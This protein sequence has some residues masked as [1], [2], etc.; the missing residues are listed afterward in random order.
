LIL[1]ESISKKRFGCSGRASGVTAAS[2][3]EALRMTIGAGEA[4]PGRELALRLMS[5]AVLI[6]FGL[7]AVWSGGWY[8]AAGA[9][10][11]AFAMGYEWGRMT[12]S[13]LT[14]AIA[15]VAALLNG[16][17]PLYPQY[18][19]LALL[20]CA[21]AVFLFETGRSGRPAAGF[22]MV[23]IA[24]MPMAFQ[25]LRA[26]DG[27][28]GWALAMGTMLVVWAS[29]SAAYF[30]GRA[31]GGPQI[32]PKYSPNKTWSGALGAT[33]A[34]IAAAAAFGVVISKSPWAWALWGGFVTVAAQAGDL[35]ESEIKRRYGVKDASGLVPGHGGV[36]DRVDGLGA[37]C[38]AAIAV[39]SAA[40]AIGV[41]L[42]GA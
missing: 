37:A 12:G 1:D 41:E 24:G 40:P 14:W 6:P 39:L 10:L 20:V 28:I 36:L 29:D 16:L 32:A 8:L 35:F 11:A 31:F 30:T 3:A 23:Y 18:A 17:Y 25:A 21:I 13:R 7:W 9:M 34:S 26:F 19:S 22:G 27:G 42:G 4:G 38:V 15:G 5:A 2:A 33:L